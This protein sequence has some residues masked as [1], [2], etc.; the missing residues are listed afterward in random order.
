MILTE[1]DLKAYDPEL[2]D[3]ECKEMIR[4]TNI[5]EQIGGVIFADL[6]QFLCMIGADE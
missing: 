2:S 6:F 1:E 5:S 4:I 3:F